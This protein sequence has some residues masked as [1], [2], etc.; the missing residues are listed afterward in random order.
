[1]TKEE[2]QDRAERAKQLL[3]NPMLKE[4]F[5]DTERALI[6]AIGLSKTPDESYKAAIAFQVFGLLKG[7]IQGHIETAKVIEFQSKQTLVDRVLGRKVQ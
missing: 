4:A 2:A 6:Q 7:C 5:E 3:S 1:M